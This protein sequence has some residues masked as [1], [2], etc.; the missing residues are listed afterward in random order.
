MTR[1]SRIHPILSAYQE[2]HGA[3]NFGKTPL[4]PIGIK[5]IVHEKPIIR[6]SWETHGVDGWYLG[7]TMKHYRCHDVYITKTRG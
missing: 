5:V 6:K 2:L 4:V 3:F 1:A 7:L